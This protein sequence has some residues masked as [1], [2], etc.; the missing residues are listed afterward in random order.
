MSNF[1]LR[2]QA[3]QHKP[4][5]IMRF[6]SAVLHVKAFVVTQAPSRSPPIFLSMVP[7]GSRTCHGPPKSRP[8][9]FKSRD[10]ALWHFCLHRPWFFPGRGSKKP[11]PLRSKTWAGH[12]YTVEEKP[13]LWKLCSGGKFLPMSSEA[14]DFGF[15]TFGSFQDALNAGQNQKKD[16]IN[17][18]SP[19]WLSCLSCL[20]SFPSSL[21]FSF[22]SECWLVDQLAG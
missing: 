3:Q 4:T 13:C 18:P 12:V 14:S 5:K 8:H 19:P 7:N 16:G 22:S 20:F 10:V 1:T 2:L 21:S 6:F 15:S 17:P 9:N 11:K